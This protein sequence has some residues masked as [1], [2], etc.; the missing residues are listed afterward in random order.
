[1]SDRA[2]AIAQFLADAGWAGAARRPLGADWSQR[3]YERL[4]GARMTAILMDA[5]ADAPV[6]PFVAVAGW[7]RGIGLHAPEVLAADPA[8]GLLL[9]EDLGDGLVARVVADGA[10]EGALYD[11]AV[12]ALAAMQRAE[13]PSWL[14]ALDATGLVALLDLFLDHATPTAGEAARAAFRADWA[15]ALAAVPLGPPR[16]LYRD[17]HAENLLVVE[18]TAGLWRLGLLDFQDAHR[19]PVAY[20]LVSLVQDARRDVAPA[21]AARAIARFRAV[22][23]ALG[24]AELDALVAVLGAQRA[25]RILGVV[26]RL[27]QRGRP[28]PE[29]LVARV[30]RHL[31]ADLR[32]DLLAPVR[33]WCARH[34]PEA[35]AGG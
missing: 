28:F 3:R 18:G 6:G 10:D 20:D 30:R 14:R 34:F 32:H 35:R 11:L 12:D 4:A 5:A 27:R 16:F 1:M 29:G 25:L 33:A 31:A 22:H 17:Y 8:A 15:Q 24:R 13:P 19:G 7:L 23:P 21:V 26:A 9:L 2:A